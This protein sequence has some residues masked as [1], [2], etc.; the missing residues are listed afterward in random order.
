MKLFVILPSIVIAGCSTL[1]PIEQR[2]SWVTLDT[3]IEINGLSHTTCFAEPN[4][5]NIFSG[6]GEDHDGPLSNIGYT[7]DIVKKTWSRWEN[8]SGPNPLQNFAFLKDQEEAYVFGGQD[9]DRPE[10]S[11]FLFRYSLQ[12]LTWTKIS[13]IDKLDPRWRPTMLASGS[14]LFFYGGKGQKSEL[15]SA[16]YDLR[17]K[18]LKMLL[19]PPQLG[20]RVSSIAAAYDSKFL[21]F[22]G[23]I[24]QT[25]RS[26][27]FI[28]DGNTDSWSEVTNSNLGPR[29]NSKT[30]LDGDKLYV[31]G[32]SVDYYH[33][34]FGSIYDFNKKNWSEIPKIEGF[35]DFKGFDIVLLPSEGIL[36]WG[37]RNKDDKYN[38]LMYFFRFKS[39]SWTTLKIDNP[40]PGTMGGCMGVTDENVVFAIGGIHPEKGKGL[41]QLKGLW[42][43]PT[44]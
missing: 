7:Y 37:G 39:N 25:R 12:N 9:A 11:N 22:G 26:D 1:A 17:Q 35:E 23:S 8:K 24:G 4:R 40:P 33:Q 42:M 38:N 29:V 31:L 10:G 34:I 19:P 28:Y 30:V 2:K 15:N 13:G 20:T 18:Q 14:R 32:G 41:S 27:G 16:V 36:F 21:I 44:N 5:I 3:P 6:I 43:L